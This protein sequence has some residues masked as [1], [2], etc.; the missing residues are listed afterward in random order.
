MS[1]TVCGG[2]FENAM[3]FI[4][5]PGYPSPY[6]HS[7]SCLYEIL[8]PPGK[9][10]SL[11]FED[12]D[13]ED[14]SYPECD[15]D[16]V[17]VIDGFDVNST[18]IGKYC[19]ASIP[20]NAIS[21]QNVMLIQFQSD[22]SIST[23]GFNATYT[24]IDVKCGGVIKSLG[25]EI[26]PPKQSSSAYEHDAD[27]VWVIVAPKG[28]I[29]QLTFS[30]FHLELSSDCELDYVSLYDGTVRNGTNIQK[31]CG[32]DLPPISQ[33][34]DN[35]LSLQF[36]SD[37]SVALDGFRAQYTFIDA[38]RGSKDSFVLAKIFKFFLSVC[39][40]TYYALTGSLRSPG[41]YV[42]HLAKGKMKISNFG[43]WCSSKHH[44]G[45]H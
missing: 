18:Q 5:S 44:L 15:F 41:L 34:S 37:S 11:H 29:V 14:T 8:A 17:T 16:F 20:A 42:P 7:R 4:T 10:I 27:C 3:G 38:Q 45:H 13:I 40:G 30:T 28:F 24:L 35:V 9:A 36:V 26:Q 39:G 32:T 12:F 23:K 33:S 22:A 21:S 6:E 2:L 43:G 1:F 19:G 31:Y 25:H